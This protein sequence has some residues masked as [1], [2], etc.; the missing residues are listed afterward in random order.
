MEDPELCAP[1]LPSEKNDLFYHF[2][3]VLAA[4]RYEPSLGIVSAKESCLAQGY[5]FQGHPPS[6]V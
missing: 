3:G 6:D 4:L 2:L 1:D 5:S